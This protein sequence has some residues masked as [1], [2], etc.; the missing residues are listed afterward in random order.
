MQ[1]WEYKRIYSYQK[2]DDIV[3]VFEKFMAENEELIGRIKIGRRTN[4]K[5][6][7]SLED[8]VHRACLEGWEL[9]TIDY[10]NKVYYFKRPLRE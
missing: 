2:D 6:G 4:A 5:V 10:T 9:F 1:K 8:A 7:E 3:E